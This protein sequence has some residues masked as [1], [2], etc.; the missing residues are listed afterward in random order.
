MRAEEAC[1]LRDELERNWAKADHTPPLKIKSGPNKTRSSFAHAARTKITDK[2]VPVDFT[3]DNDI[4]FLPIGVP[5]LFDR[6]PVLSI[7]NILEYLVIRKEGKRECL[8]GRGFT[9]CCREDAKCDNKRCAKCWALGQRRIKGVAYV[10]RE[11]IDG[12]T[13]KI[14]DPHGV[15]P[16]GKR[17]RGKDLDSAT[18][19]RFRLTSSQSHYKYQNSEWE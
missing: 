2:F 7:K 1:R 14:V 12:S 6:Q 4:N 17:A 9:K 8:V 15:D 19:A 10:V 5:T 11:V 13:P 3:S 16:K 18:R